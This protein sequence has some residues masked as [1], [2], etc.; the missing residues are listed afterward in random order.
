MHENGLGAV[1]GKGVG[2]T[3]SGVVQKEGDDEPVKQ[4]KLARL[5]TSLNRSHTSPSYV[6]A[7]GE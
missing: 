1:E 7:W 3:G 6:R 5:L 2:T 4:S